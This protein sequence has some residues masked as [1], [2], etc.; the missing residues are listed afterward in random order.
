MSS[1]IT[2]ATRL[3]HALDSTIDV[4][5]RTQLYHWNVEGLQ[6]F[7]LH[8]AFEQH[9][10]DLFAASDLVAE[11]IRALGVRVAP[12]EGHES[13]S[14]EDGDAAAM[15]ADLIT[16][17]ERAETAFQAL[18]DTASDNGD[19]VSAGLATDR[20]EFHQKTLWMLRASR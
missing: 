7:A 17:H 16:A 9:Y 11:R 10:N 12:P 6:F 2:V 4:L 15:V 18:L 13:P 3:Q 14:I 20:L 1:S 19:E 8:A 5:A